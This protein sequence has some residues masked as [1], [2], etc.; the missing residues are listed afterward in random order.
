MLCAVNPLLRS[1][2]KMALRA[3][4]HAVRLEIACHRGVSPKPGRYAC[5]VCDSTFDAFTPRASKEAQRRAHDVPATIDPYDNPLDRARGAERRFCP[6]CGQAERERFLF[7]LLDGMLRPNVRVLHTAA[8]VFAQRK[9][10][11]RCDY[12]SSDFGNSPLAM[13]RE[14]LCDLSFADT[15]LD[16]VISFHVLE[17]IP[18]DRKA[19]AEIRRVLKPGGVALLCVPMVLD[20]VTREDLGADRLER[21]HRFGHPDHFRLYGRDFAERVLAAGFAVHEYQPTRDVLP[22]IYERLGLLESDRIFR[23]VR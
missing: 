13:R 16:M 14:N 19:L 10:R 23:C 7:Y 21:L 2:V 22:Q 8:G 5:N 18:E 17:H 20:D 15:G 12:V 4:P 3:V 11:T 1:A 9:L 6:V